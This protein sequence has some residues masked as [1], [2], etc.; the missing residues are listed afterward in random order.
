MI[1]RSTISS[2]IGSCIM[3]FAGLLYGY[4]NYLNWA[5]FAWIC[6]FM[7]MI[8]IVVKYGITEEDE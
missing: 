3:F 5:L 1:Y 4:L 8:G 2:M 7:F 6:I